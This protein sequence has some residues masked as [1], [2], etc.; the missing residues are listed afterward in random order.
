MVKVNKKGF[1]EVIINSKS[2]ISNRQQAPKIFDVCTVAY[3]T[4]PEYILNNSH[5]FKG[6]VDY[7]EVKRHTS[8][9][10]DDE[11]DYEIVKKF[12]N[13]IF[14]LFS[15]KKRTAVVTGASGHLG[16]KIC[17]TLS[18]LG[19]NIILIDKKETNENKIFLSYLK[20]KYKNQKFKVF[21][22]DFLKENQKKKLILNLK[23]NKDI[24]ILINNAA[25]VPNK[26]SRG[27]IEPFNKQSVKMWENA[28]DV[29]LKSVFQI[30]QCI[31]DILRGMHPHQSK[32]IFY[33][34]NICSRFNN[35]QRNKNV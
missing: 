5:I 9:D 17:I 8:I 32:Y 7:F 31:E 20:S 34:W 2:K 16:K 19:A 15:L 35:L 21:Y 30:T 10:I 3:V 27:Y 14:N 29:N 1:V 13:M 23:K 6:N 24:S 28:F 22:A 26:G 4:T 18:E 11:F 33:I 25:F 12:F